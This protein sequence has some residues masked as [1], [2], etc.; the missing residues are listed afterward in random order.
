MLDE[1]DTLI[2]SPA[3][4]AR[5][6][7]RVPSEVEG[8]L[9]LASESRPGDWTDWLERAELTHLAGARRQLFDD[10][11]ITRQAVEDG[12]GIGV[13]PLPM[14]EI[15]IASGRLMTPLPNLRVQRT[16]YVALEPLGNGEAA[17]ASYFVGWLAAEGEEARQ[18]SR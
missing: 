10:F 3:L 14:L 5:R 11:F 15:D 17:L 12:L 18:K 8:H 6:P 16:G 2:M 1:A 9:L 13:G 7:I 4:F